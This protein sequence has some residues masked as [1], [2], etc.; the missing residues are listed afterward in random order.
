MFYRSGTRGLE[1]SNPTTSRAKIQAQVLS[2]TKASCGDSTRE[3]ATV[4]D[5]TLEVQG[6]LWTGSEM[7]AGPGQKESGDPLTQARHR[8][9]ER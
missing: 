9:T 3:Y 2:K 8:V 7:R 4:C 1:N 5:A 6:K